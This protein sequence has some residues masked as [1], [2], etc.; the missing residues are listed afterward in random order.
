MAVLGGFCVA[1][2]LAGVW[3]YRR[4]RPDRIVW[5]MPGIAALAGLFFLAYGATTKRAVPP[6]AAT[7]SRVLTERGVGTGHASGL[8]AVYNQ[9]TADQTLASGQG[10]V[11]F[12]DTQGLSDHPRRL[13]WTDAGDWRWEGLE[14]PPGVRTAPLAQPVRFPAAVEANARFGPDG[15]VGNVGPL[16]A[17][18]Y[19]DAVIAC[20]RGRYMMA[21]V[22]ADGRFRS[23][24]E[25]VL[26][27]GEY[28]SGALVSDAQ[29]RRRQIYAVLFE[30][31]AADNATSRPQIYVWTTELELGVRFS[32]AEQ[33][34]STLLSFPCRLERTAAGTDVTVPAPWIPYRAIPGPDG[35]PPVVFTN[36]KGQWVE[37]RL[38]VT[39]W[40]R[41]QL[42]ETV[43]PLDV[44][45]A[46]VSLTVRAPSRTVE[47]LVP[48]DG[49]LE[50]LVS[51]RQPIGTYRHEIDGAESIAV[52]DEGGIRLVVRVSDEEAAAT[53]DQMKQA[54]WKIERFQLEIRGRVA[55]G[56]E[57]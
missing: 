12:P 19:E 13:V 6:T 14:L 28:M 41:F 24:S 9:T 44:S 53:E 32:Q 46:T 37:T 45:G 35:D 15:I 8:A 55:G 7:V 49:E 33:R 57:R 27:E 40:F 23:G 10:G 29:M 54:T 5:F 21:A 50:P 47:L 43:L 18:D 3:L 1:I 34:H 16:P 22:D 20:P 25:D 36:F 30:S 42:P 11:V 52:D 51:W 17:A 48:R 38:G 39:E 4:D 31:V 56:Q 2:V 26:E